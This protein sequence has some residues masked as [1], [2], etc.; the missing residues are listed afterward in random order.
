MDAAVLKEIECLRRLSISGL[1]EKYRTVFGEDSRSHH[2]DFL[3]R[4][5]AWRLQAIAEGDLSERARRRAL[6]IADDADLRTRA[7]KSSR[8]RDVDAANRTV[9]GV[10]SGKRD[11]R[12][13]RPGTLLTREFKGQT[14]V[15]KVLADSFEYG[16]RSY[17]SLSAIA[18][19][20]TGTRWNG[21]TFFALNNGEKHVA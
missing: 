3:F 11:C 20:I 9:V 8:S 2:K 21:F 12:L 4:R 17:S 16:D 1:R 19:E 13:P 14:F 5:I 15:V 6:T 18:A 10:I 7:P